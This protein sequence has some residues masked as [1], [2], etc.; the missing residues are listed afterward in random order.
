[1]PQT[2]KWLGRRTGTRPREFGVQARVDDSSST[3]SGRNSIE[4]IS[5]SRIGYFDYD[6]YIDSTEYCLSQ[7]ERFPD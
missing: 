2:G 4:T 5:E 1:M 3:G 6:P 7:E